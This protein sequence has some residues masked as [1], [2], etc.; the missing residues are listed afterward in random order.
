MSQSL[1]IVC[2]LYINS[3]LHLALAQDTVASIRCAVPHEKIAVVNR[4]RDLRSDRDFI[5]QSFDR[6]IQNDQNVLARAWNLGIRAGLEAGHRQVLLPNLDIRFHPAC[7]DTLLDFADRY[8][9][10]IVWSA[11]PVVDENELSRE[12]SPVTPAAEH[13]SEVFFSCFLVD[14]RLFT[15]VGEFDEQFR[16]AYYEDVDMAYRMKIRGEVGASCPR[17]RY[18]HYEL[19]SMKG[20]AL[21]GIDSASQIR[22][23]V[24]END[25]RYERKW[26]GRPGRETLTTPYGG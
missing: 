11:T 21:V 8:P 1:A 9:R 24:G 19:G 22:L 4:I 25:I 18:F 13:C 16:P 10:D 15:Q 23:L 6:V 20:D 26:G 5:E 14:H 12:F 17:A 3:D 7:I 2:V